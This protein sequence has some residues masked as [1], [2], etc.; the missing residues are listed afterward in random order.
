MV[1]ISKL[2]VPKFKKKKYVKNKCIAFIRR[3]KRFYK[4]K[5]SIL[6]FKDFILKK[7]LNLFTLKVYIRIRSNNVF[8]TLVDLKNNIT[9]FNTSSGKYKINTTKKKLKYN[10]KVIINSFFRDINSN[11]KSKKNIIVEL[12]SPIKTRK[13]IVRI[14]KQRLKQKNLILHIKE[15]KCFNGC[16]PQ[17][18]KRKKRL[19]FRIFK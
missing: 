13:Q 7:A 5:S 9:L 14:L 1:K 18:K 6:N 16:R 17:K 10:T 12:I 2:Y 8:C 15:N 3:S 11:I 4:Y 19:T